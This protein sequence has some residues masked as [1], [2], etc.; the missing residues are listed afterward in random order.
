MVKFRKSERLCSRKSIGNLFVNGNS[1]IHYPFRVIWLDS[2]AERPFPVKIAFSVPARR[3]KKAVDRNRIKRLIR[4]SYR[5]NKNTL[6]ESPLFLNRT[7]DI[8][9]IYVSGEIYEFDYINTRLKEL[10]TK[11]IREYEA[12]KDYL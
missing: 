11:F 10:L 2:G 4:E 12:V 6:Y 3:V 7:I 9:L 5:H 1:L 8:A